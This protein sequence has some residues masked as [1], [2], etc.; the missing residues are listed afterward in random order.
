L[1]R[2]MKA[3]WD[4]TKIRCYNSRE[5]EVAEL[6]VPFLRLWQYP[7]WIMEVS[8]NNSKGEAQLS[9]AES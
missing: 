1:T 6:E 5:F 9:L 2:N 3:S 4:G 8:V 7:E